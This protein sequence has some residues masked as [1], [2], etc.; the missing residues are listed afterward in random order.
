MKAGT[1]YAEK[2][3]DIDVDGNGYAYA[4]RRKAKRGQYYQNICYA[5]SIEAARLI[6]SLL[7]TSKR[8]TG[9][10]KGRWQWQN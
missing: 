10:R 8:A 6:A 4:V 9:A 3:T 2:Q 5:N 1:Y 7:N